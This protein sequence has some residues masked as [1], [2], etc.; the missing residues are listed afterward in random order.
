M[1]LEKLSFSPELCSLLETQKTVGRSGKQFNGIPAIST[2]NN[3]LALR[4]LMLETNPQNTLEIG[5]AFGGSGLVFATTHRDLNHQPSQQHIAIDPYQ[6]KAWDD[7]GM[8]LIERSDL[9]G[10]L[11]LRQDFSHL[12]LPQL[13][14]E[15]RKFDLMYVDGSHLFEN[16]FI[17]FFYCDK[18]CEQEGIIMFDDSSDPHIRKV[19]NFIDS[20]FYRFYKK[21]DLSVYRETSGQKFKYRLATKLKKNQLTAYQKIAQS[22]RRFDEKFK[23]F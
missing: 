9:S 10:F 15:K 1:S 7:A 12:V 4:S 2:T 3:L 22:N 14:Q 18:L 5:F 13:L 20:N 17:D 8:L 21:I 19:L 6:T 16:V 23:P 11:D